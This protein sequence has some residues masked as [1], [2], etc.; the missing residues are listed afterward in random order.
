LNP[1]DSQRLLSFALLAFVILANAA[2]NVLLKIGA[3]SA[4]SRL[5][6]GLCSWQT[7]AGISCFGLS[8]LAYAWA[9]KH[10]ELH[11]AQIVVSLQYI[12]VIA[13]SVLLLREQISVAQW[14][15][16][17]LIGLGLVVCTR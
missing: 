1:L 9:L 6:F 8:V 11:V 4:A 14:W 5:L 13:L 12:T 10:I 7:A 16:I 2:G 15:G 17:A 3:N